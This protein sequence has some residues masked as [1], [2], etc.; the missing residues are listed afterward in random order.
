MDLGVHWVLVK[1]ARVSLIYR[2]DNDHQ[3]WWKCRFCRSKNLPVTIKKIL[4]DLLK[5][6][7]LK[8]GVFWELSCFQSKAVNFLK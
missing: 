2:S 4:A 8:A 7:S 6:K 5:R 1:P 3:G